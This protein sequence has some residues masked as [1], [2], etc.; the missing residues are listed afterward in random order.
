MNAVLYETHFP[1]GQTLQL[2][3]GDITAETTEAIVNAANAYLQHG[4]GVAGAILQRGGPAVQ[5][6]SDEWVRIHGPVRAETPAWTTGGNLPCRYV[7]HAVGPVWGSGNETA[8][9]AAAVSGCLRVADELRLSSLA[10]PALSTGV[11]GFPKER[12]AQVILAAIRDYCTEKH[13]ELATIRVVLYD[14]ASLSTFE[15]IWHD[16]F[17]T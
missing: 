7:I 5:H 13:S 1:A 17:G 6:E 14:R 9:L 12:A 8:R 4:A 16:Y 10:L 15:A 3:Q 2:V 11:F